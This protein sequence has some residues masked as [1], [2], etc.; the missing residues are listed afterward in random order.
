MKRIISF[1]TAAVMGIGAIGFMPETF[2][3][4]SIHAS[5]EYSGECG[6]NVTWTLDGDT[7]TIS[8]TGDMTDYYTNTLMIPRYDY[9][10]SIKRIII[11]N[12]VTSI[13]EYVFE[14]CNHLTSVPIKNT[15]CEIYD[16]GWTIDSGATI[17]GLQRFNSRGLCK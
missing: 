10:G 2:P 11:E 5:A 13:G 8:G 15:N 3:D 9:R 14:R 17:L 6:D 1:I 7:L 4:V 16:S 12:G